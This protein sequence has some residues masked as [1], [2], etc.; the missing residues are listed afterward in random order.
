MTTGTATGPVKD[1]RLLDGRLVRDRILAE[2]KERIDRAARTHTIGRLVSVS[3]GEHKEAAVYVRGQASAA[4]KVGL[5]FEEQIWPTELTQEDCKARL[6]AMNDDRT[7]LGVILQRPVPSHIRGRSLASAVHPLKD[8]EGMN[9]AS[10]GDIVYND[11]T[12]APCTAAASVELIKATG[13]PLHGLEVVMIGHSEIVGKP[14]AFM[15]MAEGATVTVCH[16]MTRS[17]A[18]HSRRADAVLVAVGKPK[19]LRADMVKPG[20]AVIDIGINQVTG[21]NGETMIVG[22]ADTENVK[23]VASWVTPVPGGVG[24]VTVAMF[25]RNAITAH[26]KQLAVGWLG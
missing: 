21:P 22:D 10:I 25:M 17:V 2:V 5:Q 11:L 19:F 3:I 26:E 18:A 6:Q 8:V 20:A 4:K 16:H 1:N 15:L 23:E 9:P 7:V 13:L 24:P 12:L 14:A